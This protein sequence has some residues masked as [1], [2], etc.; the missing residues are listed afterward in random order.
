MQRM[1]FLPACL[2]ATAKYHVRRTLSVKQGQPFVYR[3]ESTPAML[4]SHVSAIRALADSE[5]EALGF[6]PEA[7]Y[8]EAIERR[9]LIAMC[10]HR[11]GQSDIVGFILFSGVFPN[12]RVQQIV[13]ATEHRRAH[14]ATALINEVVAQLEARGYLS[15]SAA[16]ASDLPAAQ[17]FY[18]NCGFVPRLSRRGGHARNRTIVLRARD[19]AN[20]SL[21]SVLEPPAATSQT[22]VDLG[23]RLRGASQAPLYAI[24]LNVLFD[25]VKGKNRPRSTVAQRLI[26]AALGHQIRLAVAPEFVVELERTTKGEMVDPI[27]ALARQLPRLPTFDRAQT[28]RLADL[29]HTIVFIDLARPEAGSPQALSDARHL[30]EAALARASG[31]VTSDGRMLEARDQLLRQI[32][33]DVASLEEFDTLLPTESHAQENAQLKGTNCAVGAISVD[34]VRRYLQYQYHRVPDALMAEF[35]PDQIGLGAWYARAVTEAGETVAVGI[36]RQPTSIDAPAR[37]LVHV[38]SDHVSCDVFADHL[39]DVQCEEACRNGPIT[40]ELPCILGQSVV[41]RA[42]SLR[43][44]LPISHGETLIKVALGRP[45]TAESWPMIARQTRRRTGLRLPEAAPTTDAVRTGI[46]VQGPGGQTISVRLAALEDALGPTILIWPGRTGAIVPIARN[47]AGELLGTNDQFRLFGSPEAAFVSRR[48]Y[49]NS[50]RSAALLRPGRPILFYESL[51]SGGRGAIVA[52]ARIVDATVVPKDQVPE[53]ML[54]RAVV[55]DVNPLST[56]NEVLATSFDNLLRFPRPIKLDEVRALGAAS[57]AN[58]QT[59]TAITTEHLS[60]ILE[61]GWSRG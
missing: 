58:F 44:F 11:D 32:G 61:R 37:V 48:T 7:A 18:E 24:D 60:A 55:E 45:V 52:A 35:A 56:S 6:L 19:L 3:A 39:L 14:V 59:S 4:L 57:A 26:A 51:R 47:Y 13:V 1:P 21:L 38:R 10:T 15:I 42:A 25:V 23:L 41:R 33:I 54:R 22:A 8:R 31:Y 40:I 53:E 49:F 29:V 46:D 34:A 28:D 12:A 27:L 5:K 30:A 17:A 16:V 36:Y 20:E 2:A 43:G 50:P 9:R